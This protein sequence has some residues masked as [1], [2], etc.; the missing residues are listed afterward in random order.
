[1]KKRG[2]KFYDMPESERTRWAKAMPNIALD[3]VRKNEARGHPARAVLTNYMAQMR[4]HNLPIL[5]D[6]EKQ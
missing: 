5:R 4:K 1:M 6:W 2:A 3:W